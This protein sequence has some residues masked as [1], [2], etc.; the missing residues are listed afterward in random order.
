MAQ[1]AVI[2]PAMRPN[3]LP[4]ALST[5]DQSTINYRVVVVAAGECAEVARRTEGPIVVV[6]DQGGTWAQRL[7]RGYK[8]T[9]ESYIYTGADDLAWRPGWFESA[10][11]ILDSIDGVVATNDLHNMA[12]THFLLTRNYID[13]IGAALGQ[14]LGTIADEG[15]EHCYADD[16]LRSTAKHH[17]RWGGVVR[18]AVV[19]HMHPGAGKAESDEIYKIGEATMGQGLATYQERAHLWEIA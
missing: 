13:T 10:Q 6:E 17:G 14:P 7:N 11:R 2:I 16:F 9:D 8:V 5:L 12:G 19:E 18:D 15:F 4:D 3:R 1:L